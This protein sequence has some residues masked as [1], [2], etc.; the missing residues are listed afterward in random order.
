MNS[1]HCKNCK[2]VVSENDKF[3]PHCGAPVVADSPKKNAT[4]QCANCNHENPQGAS[5][6]EK[7]GVTLGES[8][9]N[10]KEKSG[11]A[12]FR[13]SGNYSGKMTKGKTSRGWKTLRNTLIIIVVLIVVAIGIWLIV[14]PKAIDKLKNIGGG[15]LVAAIFIFFVIKGNKKGRKRRGSGYEFE[16]GVNNDDDYDD[17]SDDIGDDD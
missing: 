15:I 7:C 11:P 10:Q 6:C 1:S 4:I 16:Q 8:E 12:S 2:K 5:F 13:S 17:S 14:D 3:C 9:P